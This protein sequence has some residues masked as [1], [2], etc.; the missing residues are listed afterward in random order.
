V[1][2]RSTALALALAA[3]SCHPKESGVP[4]LC[5]FDMASEGELATKALPPETWLRLVSPTVDKTTMVR[6]G[7]LKDGC[8][9][10]VEDVASDPTF[11]CP[12]ARFETV[13]VADDRV[14][15]SDLIMSQVGA[16]RVLL[17]AATDELVDGQAFGSIALAQ[18]TERGIEIH[19]AGVVRGHRQG[20]RMRLHHASGIPVLVL[21]SDRC[22]R[23]NACTRVGQFVPMLARRFREVPLFEGARGCIGRAQFALTRQTE[24]KLDSR[25]V[26]RFRMS[27][28]IELADSGIVLTDLVI[29]EDFDSGDPS[30]PPTPFRRATA[31]RPLELADGRFELRD[32]DLWERV[33]RDYG[34]VRGP[35]VDRR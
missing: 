2:V 26:R 6:N 30:T 12:A 10:V 8:G 3:I 20:A 33:L 11:G 18:W 35:A 23:A 28:N 32:E 15:A 34:E 16:D 21:E 1:I 22:D 24:V 29:V 25:W 19:G 17:W 5:S 14:E 7:P 31:S 4:P 13:V 9:R 27:R